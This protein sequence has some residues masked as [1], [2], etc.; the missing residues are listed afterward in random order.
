MGTQQADDLGALVGEIAHLLPHFQ[1]HQVDR[2]KFLQH[3]AQG[4]SGSRLL[5]L[6][7]DG[8]IRLLKLLS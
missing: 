8:F 4:W 6:V 1:R 7:E 2:L 5:R 3:P